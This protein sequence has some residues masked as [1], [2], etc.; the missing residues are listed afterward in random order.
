MCVFVAHALST[1]IAIRAGARTK[2]RNTRLRA[3]IPSESRKKRRRRDG[4]R[5]IFAASHSCD[6]F[7]FLLY[8]YVALLNTLKRAA[9]RRVT[10][11]FWYGRL[12]KLSFSRR[13]LF[14]YTQIIAFK[15]R[16]SICN[17]RAR[18]LS[19]PRVYPRLSR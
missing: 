11:H 13:H 9:S 10:P 17:C 16:K 4:R 19:E 12:V 8:R 5:A 18:E 7:A 1:R 14:T 2:A 3:N 6:M 15:L